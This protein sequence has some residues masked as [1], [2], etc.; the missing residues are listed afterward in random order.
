MLGVFLV[1]L[2]QAPFFF[3]VVEHDKKQ[4]RGKNSSSLPDGKRPS[5]SVQ[6]NH[7]LNAAKILLPLF[8]S[9]LRGSRTRIVEIFLDGIANRFAI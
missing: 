1:M 7:C 2:R 3:A 9:P 4:S 8:C 5:F 6:S